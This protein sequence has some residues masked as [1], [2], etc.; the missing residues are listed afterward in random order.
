MEA[1]LPKVDEISLKELITCVKGWGNYLLKKWITIFLAGVFGGLLGFA[2]AYT[3]KPIYTA[4]TTFVLEEGEN[5][6]GLSSYAGIASMVGIDLNSGGGGVFQGDNIL[7]LY[8]SRRMI[9]ETLLSV[10]TFDRKPSLLINRFLAFNKIRDH[11]QDNPELKGLKFDI[12]QNSFT[13]KHD[14]IIGILVDDI[15]NH[16]LQVSKPDKKLSIIK[17]G[18]TSEDQQF[19]KSFT[20]NIVKTVNEFYIKTKTKKS[21]ENITILQRQA[22]SVRMVLNSSI[23]GVAAEMDVNPNSNSAFQTLRVPSQRRQIDVQAN[24]AIY[25]EIV[26]NLELGK[27]TLRKEKPLI[28]I[29]DEPVLPLKREKLGKLKGLILGGI[30]V[31]TLVVLILILKEAFKKILA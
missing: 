18:V 8:K 12:P 13:L 29:I 22:D 26:K 11:W 16:Y 4:E 21:T 23:A 5:S 2:Y 17:V 27:A 9:Q 19:A 24:S 1:Q 31:G 20:T 10:D 6:G 28:Q 3:Q 7:E 30:I 25:Q 14:S 15:N